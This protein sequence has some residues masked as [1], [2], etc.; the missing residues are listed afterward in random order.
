LG[1]RRTPFGPLISGV[2]YDRFR[3]CAAL[4][5]DCDAIAGRDG[6][7]A[8]RAF[9]WYASD[10][11]WLPLEGA[12]GIAGA[13]YRLW[14]SHAPCGVPCLGNGNIVDVVLVLED[15]GDSAT[16]EKYESPPLWPGEGIPGA[17]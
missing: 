15:A 13:V 9:I 4:A 8:P 7:C 5:C 14:S 16:G 10:G 17:I 11:V 6:R 3:C 1:K 12:R 2:L